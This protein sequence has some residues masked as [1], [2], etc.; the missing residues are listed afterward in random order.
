MNL[1]YCFIDEP[2]RTVNCQGYWLDGGFC[3]F[4]ISQIN[5]KN[6]AK[7]FGSFNNPMNCGL[8][9]GRGIEKEWQNKYFGC[10]ENEVFGDYERTYDIEKIAEDS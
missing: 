3:E 2:V 8:T 6:G 4:D 7:Y 9:E 10:F 1:M 5:F